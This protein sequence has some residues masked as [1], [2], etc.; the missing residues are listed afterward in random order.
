MIVFAA[1]LAPWIA[2]WATPGS[3]SRLIMSPITNT[4]GCPGRVRS[5]CTGTRPGRSTSMPDW[6]AS[7]LPSGLACTP[8]AHTLQ[9]A[10]TRSVL[11]SLCLRSRPVASRLVTIALSLISTPMRSSSL[12]AAADSLAERRQHHGGRVEETAAPGT[13]WCR[14]CGSSPTVSCG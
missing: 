2:T 5:G 7:V 6:S 4:L 1:Y 9:I 13:A 8:A 10:S 11:P 14:C 3:R 12:A